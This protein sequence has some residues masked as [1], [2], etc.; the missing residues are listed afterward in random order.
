MNNT[1]FRD[2]ISL[3]A[4]LMTMLV[5]LTLPLI[6]PPANE[7]QAKPPGSMAV[8]IFWPEGDNDVD[9]WIVGPLEPTPIGYSNKGGI[10]WNLLRDDLGRT[11]DATKMNFENA[12]TRGLL[13]GEY[14]VNIHCYRCRQFPIPVEVEITLQVNKKG[15]M[16]KIISTGIDMMH[17]GQERTAIRF[18]LDE[19]GKMV[20]GSENRVFMPLRSGEKP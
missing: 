9:L 14:I 10:M 18:K 4:L 11:A 7:G 5:I 13:A 15:D 1:L 3:L 16:T 2:A 8:H 17:E 20:P 12:Y 19:E 6:N